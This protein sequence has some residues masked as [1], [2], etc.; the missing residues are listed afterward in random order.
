MIGSSPCASRCAAAARPT[1][2]APITATGSGESKSKA[3]GIVDHPFWWQHSLAIHHRTLTMFD[4]RAPENGAPFRE[5]AVGR[6]RRNR[7]T[8][9][10]G[11]RA[12]TNALIRRL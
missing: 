6:K 2:P 7:L 11:F 3:T 9:V 10:Y 4:G 8:V 12:R 1:G 5:T